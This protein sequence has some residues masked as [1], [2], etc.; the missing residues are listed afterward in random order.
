MTSRKTAV[1]PAAVVKPSAPV[2]LPFQLQTIREEKLDL[3]GLC[4]RGLEIEFLCQYLVEIQNT[5]VEALAADFD[6]AGLLGIVKAQQGTLPVRLDSV[7]CNLEIS[8]KAEAFGVF[9]V[10]GQQGSTDVLHRRASH[11]VSA[12]M[13]AVA[14]ITIGQ[15]QY[16]R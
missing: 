9:V 10:Q 2:F 8:S 11:F 14:V 4:I 1:W 12:P 15:K 16:I 5:V 6:V 7:K 13:S 3:K